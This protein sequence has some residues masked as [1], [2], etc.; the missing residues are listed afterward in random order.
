MHY[1]SRCVT[2]VNKCVNN[3]SVIV[4]PPHDRRLLLYIIIKYCLI[5][6]IFICGL[7]N[8]AVTSRDYM[9]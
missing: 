4:L 6:C 1:L 3:S 9:L 7:C 2:S 5:I 8:D